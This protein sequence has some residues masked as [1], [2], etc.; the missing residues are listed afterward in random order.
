MA[1]K[2]NRAAAEKVILENIEAL[3]PGS[4]NAN[5]YKEYF[6]GLSD[7]EFDKF[8]NGLSDNTINLCIVDANMSES[9]LSV[10]RNLA[11]AKK[12]GHEFRERI[13][14]DEGD[15]TPRYLTNP[16]YMIV[17]LPLRRQSQ[18]QSKKE[19]I[20]EH[21]RSI[22]QLSGQ[23]T[24]DSKG[25]KIS[26]PELQI[27]AAAGLDQCSLELMK[28]RGGDV[29]AFQAMNKS[30]HDTG[31]ASLEQLNKLG[32]SVVATE[33]LHIYLTG[34]HLENTLMAR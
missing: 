29:Q 6:A 11:L 12:L 34:M 16:K 28:M 10:E 32:T 1:S 5:N 24:G 9:R 26:Y 4:N 7:A 25:S 33:I 30:I 22:D 3:A 15:G 14:I 21:N 23:P 13:W 18:L 8:I 31:G 27:L 19:S 2:G 17:D 20:P